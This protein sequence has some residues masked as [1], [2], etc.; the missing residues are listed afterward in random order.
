MLLSDTAIKR[1]VFAIVISLLLVAFGLLAFDRLALREYPDIDPPIISISTIYV[2]AS[3]E[4]VESRVTQIIEERIAGI[5]GIKSI[6]S[7]SR[8]GFS[9]INIEFKLSRDV[10]AAAND[11]RDRVAR[12]VADL[13]EEA[14]PPEVQKTDADEQVIMW[15]NL[16]SEQHNIL[17]LADYAQRHIVDR[18]AVLDGVARVRISGGPEYAMRIWLDRKSLAARQLTVSDVENA[19]RRENVELPAG[20]LQSLERDFVVKIN[21]HY[22]SPPDFEG[23]VVKRD[24][25][26]Y[27][28]R[29]GDVA[30]VELGAA[31][32]RQ[33]FQGNGIPMVGVGVV[34]QSVSNTLAVAEAV[35]AE[36]IKIRQSLPDGIELHSSFDSSVFI[37]RAISE[38]YSTLAIAAVLVV[39]VIFLF[40]GD[41]RAMLVPAVTVPVSL[42]AT[43]TVLYALGYTI[44]LLTLLALVLAIGLVVDDSIVVLENIHRRLQNGEPPLV[45]A[46]RGSRQVGFAVLATTAV[47]VAVFV[48]ISF[49]DGDVGRLFGEFAVAMAVA[50]VFSS[51]VALTLSPVICS[52]VLRKDAIHGSL[53]NFVEGLLHRMESRYG[54]LLAGSM[55]HSIIAALAVA[56]T[57]GACGFFLQKVPTEFAPKEDRGVMFLVIR[58]PEGASYNYVTRQL[59]E[60]EKRL[61]P[62]VD[63]GIVKRLLLRA[64]GGR[65]GADIY[66]EANGVIV[67]SPWGERENV[68]KVVAEIRQRLNGFTGLSVYPILPQSLSGG[69]SKPVEFVIGGSNYQDLAKWSDLL[70]KEAKTNPGLLGIDSDFRQTKPQLAVT[71][72]R[73]RAATLGVDASE[74][75]RSLETLLGS[76]RVT[77]FM[78]GGEEY[79]VILEGEPSS[80]HSPEDLS[81]I[82]VRSATTGTLIPLG[83][84]VS[85][86]ERGDAAV[87]NR[88]N[89][90]RAI[91]IDANLANGYSLGE[92]LTYLEKVA[93]DNFPNATIDFKGESLDYREAGNAVYFTFALALLVVFLVLAAQFESFIHPFIILLSVPLAIAGALAGLYLSG[94]SLNI[95]SQ[96]ALIMLVG[97]AAKNGIL[98]VEFANQLRDQGLA[99]DDAVLQSA[100]QRLRPIVMT[101]FTTIM[102]AVPL[103][104]SSGP[105]SESRYV[106][107]IVVVFGVSSATFLTL[108]VIPMAY[109]LLAKNTKSPHTVSRQL[110]AQLAVTEDKEKN[111]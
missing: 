10:D 99:F 56:M 108:F 91:T 82:Y 80:Q 21:R 16:S 65:G 43:F 45:A 110:E 7:S 14:D 50:V 62:M 61:M 68:T 58:G 101:A 104:L 48:P 17:E 30:R 97:L 75:N 12:V 55:K 66:N 6:N 103:I 102:G 83:N 100:R 4:V 37:A 57:I 3:A 2:G 67:L 86:Q 72:N 88:Y 93:A 76:R 23:L 18:L 54:K 13:P 81:N 84:L 105:G 35:R 85:L 36:V 95:Y 79:D 44:N 77:T 69:F 90:V 5:E 64:P 33:S 40:L 1:P 39:L 29:L 96:I 9:S 22:L 59:G 46:Y 63:A 38:V 60:I 92:A 42:I 87:L 24:E 109:R 111:D 20:T 28:T 8:D 47:L 94:Q 107:G 78:M 52:K 27:L 73:D 34:K 41:F 74:I 70:I 31:E 71:I 32:Y 51:L 98:L 89:R 15:H 19:L 106:I 25:Q 26:G 49:L 11:V 53:G